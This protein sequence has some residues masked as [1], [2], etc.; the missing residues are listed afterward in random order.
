[1]KATLREAPEGGTGRG[2]GYHTLAV[3]TPVV[4][5]ATKLELLPLATDLLDAEQAANETVE[6]RFTK[7]GLGCN[8]AM[9]SCSEVMLEVWL[10]FR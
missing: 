2:V 6:Q 1:L 9:V 4:A 5:T 7:A 8:S 3:A 10:V